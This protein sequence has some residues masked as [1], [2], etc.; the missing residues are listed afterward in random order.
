MKPEEIVQH[1]GEEGLRQLQDVILD[2]PMRQVANWVLEFYTEQQIGEWLVQLRQD[3][4][5]GEK[6]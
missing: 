3:E 6:A 4:E 2:R 5:E 1:F